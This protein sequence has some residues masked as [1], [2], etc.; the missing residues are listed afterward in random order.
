[1]ALHIGR[2]SMADTDDIECITILRGLASAGWEITVAYWAEKG[3][4]WICDIQKGGNIDDPDFFF[5]DRDVV[6]AVKGAFSVW[7]KY[8]ETI[9][10]E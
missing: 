2:G 4:R 8:I 3:G 1:M 5:E 7:K 10:K 9:Q 6:L